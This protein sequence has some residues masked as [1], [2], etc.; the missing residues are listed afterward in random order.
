MKYL[1]FLILSIL[2]IGLVYAEPTP[3][4]KIAQFSAG[5]LHGWEEKEF[6]GKTEYAFVLDDVKHAKVLK[7][8]SIDGASGLFYEQRIDLKETPFL[9]WSWKT[10][11]FF[12][13]LDE[14]KK[15]GDD[16]TARIYVVID[17]GYFF[18][19][20]LALNYVWS[21]SHQKGDVWANPFTS[22]ATMVAV[23]AGEKNLGV[24]QHNKRNV[25]KDLKD[26]IGQDIQ[27]IDAIAIMTDTDNAGLQATTYFGDVFFTSE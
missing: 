2:P 22:N 14:N 20:T 5:T 9:N 23:E 12:K 7:A 1:I 6:D 11:S 26:F 19:K 16:F 4:I 3:P 27:Y 25:L 18:W 17:G 8:T 13:G 15:S 24:W 10:S 21:A